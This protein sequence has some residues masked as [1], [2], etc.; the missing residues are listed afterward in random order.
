MDG[1]DP[2]WLVW[3]AA[4]D[5]GRPYLVAVDT[6]E[7][8]AALHVHAKKDEARLLGKIGYEVRVEQS[9]LDHLYGES[10][11]KGFDHAKTMM[12]EIIRA[13]RDE[14]R[15]RLRAAIEIARAGISRGWHDI[16]KAE[17]TA[18]LDDL[19]ALLPPKPPK[20]TE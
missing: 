10:M 7:K 15:K 19:E 13:E 9:W 12:R 2:C 1:F 20:E 16:D 5:G 14:L 18:K 11:T 8:Q 3:E 4:T 17:H 6:S